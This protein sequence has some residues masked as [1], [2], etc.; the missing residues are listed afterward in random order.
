[1]SAASKS[2]IAAEFAH[3]AK[4]FHPGEKPMKIKFWGLFPWGNVSPYIK[5][6]EIIPND[7]YTRENR[8]I[9]CKPSQK[10]Y[11]KWIVPLLTE[12]GNMETISEKQ[13]IKENA[14]RLAEHHKKHCDGQNCDI[15]LHLVRRALELAGIDL[16]EDEKR[17]FM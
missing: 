1:M 7:G 17:L 9:W 5:T 2:A 3:Q 12:N 10:F 14:M 13:A 4:Q 16:T 11:D 6:G 8:I 15:S